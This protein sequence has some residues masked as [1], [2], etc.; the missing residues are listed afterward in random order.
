MTD[1]S[2]SNEDD[3]TDRRVPYEPEGIL[4]PEDEQAVL[5]YYFGDQPNVRSD[6]RHSGLHAPSGLFGFGSNR[7]S[8]SSAEF[9]GLMATELVHAAKKLVK[10]SRR[11]GMRLE[12]R[13]RDA[14]VAARNAFVTAI[15]SNDGIGGL[16]SLCGTV[17]GNV[18]LQA[19][20]LPHV[21]D[22]LAEA[23]LPA[24]VVSIYTSSLERLSPKA[25]RATDIGLD[26]PH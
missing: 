18:V 9:I 7:P 20:R 8:D 3:W 23:G 21:V 17:A 19:L 5:D 4:S 25:D 16:A 12:G 26:P 6:G 11:P 10:D 15:A 14:N 24:E 13:S 1:D 2:G 22:D